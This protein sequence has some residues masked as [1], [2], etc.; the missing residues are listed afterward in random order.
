MQDQLG[1]ALLWAGQIEAARRVY[2]SILDEDPSSYQAHFLMG[3][4]NRPTDPAAALD[5]YDRALAE[6]DSPM[7]WATRSKAL[8]NLGRHQ[9]A[10]QTIARLETRSQTEYISPFA[11]GLAYLA[12]GDV[13]KAFDCL[14]ESAEIHDVFAPYIRVVA[15]PW[16]IDEDHPR[17]LALKRRIWPDEFGEP[18]E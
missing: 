10:D 17:Y 18:A 15:Q 12:S 8:R 3:A 6:F 1:T 2:E 16:G 9:E 13:D 7:V 5:H 14:E 4:I 11:M